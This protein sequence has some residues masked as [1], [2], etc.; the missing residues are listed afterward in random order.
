MTP[1]KNKLATIFFFSRDHAKARDVC[2]IFSEQIY[3]IYEFEFENLNLKIYEFV[4]VQ[5]HIY[6][7]QF[8]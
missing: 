7:M 6:S 8:G 2:M 5:T 4:H 1:G 3:V